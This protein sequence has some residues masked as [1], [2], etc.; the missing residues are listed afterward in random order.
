M[1]RALSYRFMF[2]ALVGIL[3][4]W[5]SA[6]PIDAGADRQQ[7]RDTRERDDEWDVTKPRGVT[8]EIDFTTSEG[9]WMSVDVTPDGGWVV[10]DLLGHVYRVAA[11]G[12]EATCLTQDSGIAVNFHP[13]ISPDG[14]TI[15]FV[16]DR[17]GQNNLWL[18]DVDGRNARPVSVNR[19]IRVFEPVWTPDGRNL[20]VRR[21]ST[22]RDAGRRRRRHLHVLARGRRGRSH[23]PG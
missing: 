5:A 9:T 2:I 3:Y 23:R 6:A 4:P 15:A 10:F 21:T 11:S 14:K 19:D 7:T 18:M 20:I 17:R 12:G 16:S 1:R 13:R 22:A 8:R